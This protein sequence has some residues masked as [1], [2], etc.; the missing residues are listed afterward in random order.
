MSIYSRHSDWEW[1]QVPYPGLSC[2]KCR[3]EIKICKQLS[4]WFNHFTILQASPGK[5]LK[6]AKSHQFSHASYPEACEKISCNGR[7]SDLPH[8]PAA[9][10]SRYM[11]QWLKITVDIDLF[12]GQGLQQRAL[13]RIYT[14]FPLMSWSPEGNQ[15]LHYSIKYTRLYRFFL[16]DEKKIFTSLWTIFL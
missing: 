15:G 5:S 13:S 12:T 8:Q 11:E 2:R 3:P 9:F 1:Y 14:W 4:A 10:P 16:N 7:F 6:K